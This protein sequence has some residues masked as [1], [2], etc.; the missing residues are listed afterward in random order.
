M[1]TFGAAV[2]LDPAAGRNMPI[3][4][5][6]DGAF[7]TSPLDL[8]GTFPAQSK[9][10]LITSTANEA[11]FGI[12]N[13]FGQPVPPTSLQ[14]ICDATFGPDRTNVILANPLYSP[15]LAPDGTCDIRTQLQTI[16]TD[17]LWRCSS[18]SFA[19]SWVQNGGTAYVAQY[20]LGA[21]YPGN[22]VVP[23][24]TQPGVVCHQ[25]DIE[26]VVCDFPLMIPCSFY[27]APSLILITLSCFLHTC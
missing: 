3:R 2:S 1:N 8:S 15:V 17:Y 23:Y 19:R 5:V 10:L 9:P 14:Y 7:I 4:P 21:S 24:C 25:D 18:W 27:A 11:G 12:Y 22:E 26:I 20:V 13:V 16:G 6:L